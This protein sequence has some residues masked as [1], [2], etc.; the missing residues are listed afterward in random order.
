MTTVH[1]GQGPL[2]CRGVDDP[3]EVRLRTCGVDGPV[4]R[5]SAR[6]RHS[7]SEHRGQRR[8]VELQDDIDTREASLDLAHM[9][10]GCLGER[11][12]DVAA[13]AVVAH[14]SLAAAR[15]DGSGKSPRAGQLSLERAAPAGEGLLYPVEVLRQPRA[16]P[17]HHPA[18]RIG[19]PPADGGGLDGQI[20]CDLCEQGHGAADEVRSGPSRGQLRDVGEVGQLPRD[21]ARPLVRVGARETA[22][23]G[24]GSWRDVIH[25]RAIVAEPTTRVPS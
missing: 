22:D 12:S 4:R 25:R 20:R 6:C 7:P 2:T 10:G 1:A 16:R 15:L 24:G 13:G 11:L 21:R 3:G 19:E 5:Q 18:G 8:L 17:R 14:G 9:N 23:S